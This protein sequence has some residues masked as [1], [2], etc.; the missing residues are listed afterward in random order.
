MSSP[1][2]RRRSRRSG[3]TFIEIMLVVVIIGILAALVT[4]NIMEILS[5]GRVNATKSQMQNIKTAL[6]LFNIR[7][8]VY[9]STDQGLDALV[10]CPSDVDEDKYGKRMLDQVP[11]DG[12]GNEYIY[13]APGEDGADYD[14][15][16]V[17]PDG[18]EGTDDDV[19]L[20][21]KDEE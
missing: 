10:N 5:Q 20:F 13:R 2:Q 19:S 8:Y 18:E 16:S 3:F 7:C 6:D 9:P 11:K 1:L 21:D 14:L 4:P 17:G 12:W 15:F